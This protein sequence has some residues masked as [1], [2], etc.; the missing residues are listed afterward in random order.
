MEGFVPVSCI[1]DMVKLPI[2][3]KVS[4]P[5]ALSVWLTDADAAPVVRRATWRKKYF[6]ASDAL[7]ATC[8]FPAAA[9][10]ANATAHLRWLPAQRS[11]TALCGPCTFSPAQRSLTALCGLYAEFMF[12][13]TLSRKHAGPAARRRGAY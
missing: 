6:P 10:N 4:V 1:P 12:I 5:Q 11:L 2:P 8:A 7:V 13:T 9:S 3:S